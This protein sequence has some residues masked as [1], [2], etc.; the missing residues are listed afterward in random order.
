MKKTN[1]VVVVR[2][3]H[4]LNIVRRVVWQDTDG[5]RYFK[6]E[7]KLWRLTRYDGSFSYRAVVIK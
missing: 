6:N 1:D 2:K 5:E 7:G 4:S 3:T